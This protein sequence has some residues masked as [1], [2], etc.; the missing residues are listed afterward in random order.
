MTRSTPPYCFLTP[1]YFLIVLKHETP[2]T[3]VV[4]A[5]PACIFRALEARGTNILRSSRL[6]V[7]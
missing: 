3:E 2:Q 7:A 4:H 1:H 5:P 6:F